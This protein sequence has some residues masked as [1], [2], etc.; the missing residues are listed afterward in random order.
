MRELTIAVVLLA[1][2]AA[3]PA[4]AASGPLG[5]PRAAQEGVTR[6]DGL[7]ATWDGVPLDTTVVLPQA[8][9]KRLP[10]VALV[11][12]VGNSH[13]ENLDPAETAYTGNAYAWAKRG[14]AVLV[15]T[16]RGLWG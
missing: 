11:H 9:A 10:L 14:Y 2:L 15:H 16:A 3:A 4:R 13:Q 7:V 8:G 1:A 6:C 12:G 5:L